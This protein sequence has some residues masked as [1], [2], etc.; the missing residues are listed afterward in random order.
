MSSNQESGWLKW[1][2]SRDNSEFIDGDDLGTTLQ[3]CGAV[4]LSALRARTISPERLSEMTGLPVAFCAV[5]MANLDASDLWNQENFFGLCNIIREHPDDAVEIE[6]TLNCFLEDFWVRSSLPGI[7]EI[8]PALRGR[9]LLFGKQQTWIDEER[10]EA[11][12][13]RWPIPS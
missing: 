9:S 10:I 4:V 1:F 3:M 5:T 6:A 8:L 12:G 11:L 7:C 2:Y 13:S